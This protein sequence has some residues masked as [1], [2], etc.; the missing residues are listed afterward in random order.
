MEIRNS[1]L[2]KQGMKIEIG[3]HGSSQSILG[4]WT[5]PNGPGWPMGQWVDPADFLDQVRTASAL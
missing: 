3:C 4:L 1:S 2:I 5:E